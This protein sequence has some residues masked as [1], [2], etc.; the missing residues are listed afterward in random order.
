MRIALHADGGSSVGLGHLG[1]CVALAQAFREAGARPEFVD[2]APECRP[3]LRALGFT[4]APLSSRRWDLAIGD[5]YRLSAAGW[6][7]LGAAARRLL[8]IDDGGRFAGRCDFLLNG[9]VYAAGLAYRARGA[10]L[11][12]GP[13]FFPMRR[14]Y[15]KSGKQRPAHGR[16]RRV[17]VTLGAG[18]TSGLAARC[19]AAAA[20][21]LP[22]A[23]VT[24]V[25]GPL[26]RQDRV[27]SPSVERLGPQVSL[28]PLLERADIVICAGGQTLYEAAFCGAPA[29][30]LR[31]AANQDGNIDGMAAAGTAL[32]AGSPSVAG[33]R[34]RLSRLLRSL[35]RNRPL[36]E[37]MAQ[38][39]R[40]VVDGLGAC[41][42]AAAVA[43]S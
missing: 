13:A 32:S 9:H 14:E 12:L 34:R 19:A 33:F 11:L 38:A 1:R 27:A 22:G 28:R 25:A 18:D 31:L 8:V 40:A 17:V 21:A 3:W 4:D 10:S 30:V 43:A 20:E 26:S 42:V 39:G 2:L 16:A 37:R 36:R 5:S 24:L 7:R 23:A 35:D 6:R 29:V 15:W 41:R